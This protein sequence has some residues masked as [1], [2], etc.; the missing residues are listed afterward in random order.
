[1]SRRPRTTTPAPDRPSRFDFS[2]VDA[3]FESDG[4][5]CA[6]WLYRP[7]SVSNPPVVIMAPGFAAE[8][9]FGLPAIAE[10]FAEAGYAAFLFDYRHF[11]D[12]EGTPRQLVSVRRQLADWRA[13]LDY[14]RRL[15][16]VDGR[17]PVLW[18]ASLAGGHVLRLAA[19]ERPAAVVAV[20]PMVDGRAVVRTRSLRTLL[21]GGVAAV[22]DRLG[23]LIG[24]PHTVPVVGDSG[25]F[26]ALS[27][28]GV[29]SAVLSLVP[30]DTEWRNE[31]PARCLLSL[32]RYRPIRHAG[33]ISCPTLVL[34]AGRDDVVP[35]ASVER[36]AD[37]VP[38]ATYVRLP[39]GHFD[40]YDTAA[41]RPALRHELAFLDATV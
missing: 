13:A 24:R 4:C 16:G 7:S 27:N 40:V 14:V 28:P 23:G 10:R 8:R 2:K 36:A 22:R 18:G 1:M 32:A 21:R 37:A 12:S 9:T 38:D 29:K 41:R 17:R 31:V 6:G 5:R 15:D 20:V 34:G 33:D 39:V 30:D 11:G 26:A 25:E 35:L 3:D 19:D